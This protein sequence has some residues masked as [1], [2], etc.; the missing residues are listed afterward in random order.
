MVALNI[1]YVSQNVRRWINYKK[2]K[3]ENDV[4]LLCLSIYCHYIDNSVVLRTLS[5]EIWA[6]YPLLPLF[7]RRRYCQFYFYD[8]FVFYQKNA[9]YKMLN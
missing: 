2:K 5:R 6:R 1:Q 9:N 3:V 4:F 8:N 7:S